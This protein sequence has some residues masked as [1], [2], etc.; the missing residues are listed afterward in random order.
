MYK[1]KQ[2]IKNF[3]NYRFYVAKWICRKFPK[4]MY[5]YRKTNHDLS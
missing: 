4:G 2:V 1:S 5:V 3:R